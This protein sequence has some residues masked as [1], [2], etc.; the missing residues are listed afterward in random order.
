MPHQPPTTGLGTVCDP[1]L[2]FIATADYTHL[3]R[4]A[5][6]SLQQYWGVMMGEA[7]IGKTCVACKIAA[8]WGVGRQWFRTDFARYRNRIS[9]LAHALPA[10]ASLMILDDFDY[11]N[12][13]LVE[14]QKLMAPRPR[15]TVLLTTR[16]TEPPPR[17][18]PMPPRGS[19]E[20][21]RMKGMTNSELRQLIAHAGFV[22]GPQIETVLGASMGNPG[23]AIAQLVQ[24]GAM[25]SLFGS[26]T[27]IPAVLG[28]DGQ[29]LAVES[30][31][32]HAVVQRVRAIS[33]ALI[34][35]LAR[36]PRLMYELDWRK[37]E[38]LVAELYDR[39][40]YDV[41]LT[42]GSRDS[43]VDIYAIHRAP[44]ASFLTVI[45]CKKYHARHPVGVELVRQ[46]RSAAGDHRAHMGV[47]A[48]SSY[49]TKGAKEYAQADEHILGLQDFVSIHEMLK[50]AHLNS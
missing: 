44:Y 30:S 40:G 34:A 28:P 13:V 10:R 14:L 7:G 2:P 26:E 18:L 46:L 20:F 5:M 3:Y 27:V 32:F 39:E 15:L 38:E 21:Y 24:T 17:V 37:F 23:H 33:D 45:D 16:A 49:F 31:G 47:I 42:R 22:G 19:I 8:D 48:T 25:G 11:E 50:R 29:S 9:D 1:F 12:D 6:S 35:R 41:E 43:G 36:E 4:Q